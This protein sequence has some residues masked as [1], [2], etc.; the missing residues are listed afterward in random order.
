VP[1]DAGAWALFAMHV[2]VVAA[3]CVAFVRVLRMLDDDGDDWEWGDDHGGGGGGSDRRG[4]RGP[5][6]GGLPLDRLDPWPRRLR[7]ARGRLRVRLPRRLSHGP[8]R[9]RTPRPVT[10]RPPA[11]SRR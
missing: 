6:G 10:P 3:S 9:P 4:P 1:D 5:W 2:I 11:P 7:A 8:A